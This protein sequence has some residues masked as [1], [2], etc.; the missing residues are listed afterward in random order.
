[1][2]QR[3]STNVQNFYKPVKIQH[4]CV[5]CATFMCAYITTHQAMKHNALSLQSALLTTLH[6]V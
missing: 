1:M 2:F 6:L 4:E 3:T 5:V